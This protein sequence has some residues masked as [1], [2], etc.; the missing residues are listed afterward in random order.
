MAAHELSVGTSNEYYTPR[1]VFEAM[2]IQFDLDVSAPRAEC[3]AYDFC[4]DAYTSRSLER[5]WFGVVWMNPPFGGRGEIEPWLA[6]FM[7][8]GCGVA[9]TPD[10]TSAPWWQQ[11]AR[12]PDLVLFVR[13]KIKFLRPDGTIAK[14]PGTGTTLWAMGERGVEALLNAERA[15]LGLAFQRAAT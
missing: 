1:H 9:L 15:G 10:R 8:H 3:P 13:E 4:D 5:G 12:S 14:Q 11:H 2:G 7:A 6:K